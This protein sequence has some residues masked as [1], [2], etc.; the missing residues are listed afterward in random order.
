MRANAARCVIAVLAASLLSGCTSSQWGMPNLAFWKRSPFHSSPVASP[1][2]LGSPERPAAVAARGRAPANAYAGANDAPAWSPPTDAP[3]I[4]VTPG[5]EYPSQQN[6]YP[7]NTPGQGVERIASTA[8]IPGAGAS[9]TQPSYYNAPPTSPGYNP[10]GS[11]SAPPPNAPPPYNGSYNNNSA[12][13]SGGYDST[14]APPQG[15]NPAR[16]DASYPGAQPST[17]YGGSTEN[18]AAPGGYMPPADSS[19]GGGYM[20][21]VDSPYGGGYTPPS[22]NSTNSGGYDSSRAQPQQPNYGG[23]GDDIPN[24]YSPPGG[25]APPADNSY[26]PPTG[27]YTPPS[28]GYSPPSGSNI[29]PYDANQPNENYTPPTGGYVPPSGGYAPPSG[30]AP[31]VGSS[32]NS[33]SAT[34]AATGSGGYAPPPSTTGAAPSYRPGSTSDYVPNY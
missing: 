25:Y 4:N 15:Y 12:P 8:G 31:L 29:P 9:G 27:G 5:T 20:P 18:N 19:Y 3:S 21:P 34:S 13:S 1:G 24:N 11:Y 14:A 2:K 16:P 32:Y 23:A 17:P 28:D 10:G 26:T 6:P 7:T 30:N 22:Y 33:P